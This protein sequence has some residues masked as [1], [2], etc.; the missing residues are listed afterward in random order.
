MLSK[1]R[2]FVK[3]LGIVAH[4]AQIAIWVVAGCS[5]GLPGLEPWMRLVGVLS[6]AVLL[7]LLTFV[8]WIMSGR[9]LGRTPYRHGGG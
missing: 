7:V 6:S 2:D 5:V 1:V 4:Q 9:A 8:V 3:R